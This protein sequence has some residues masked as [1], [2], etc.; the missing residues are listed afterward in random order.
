MRHP[1]NLF[2]ADR[3]AIQNRI[4]IEAGQRTNHAGSSA[5]Q[6]GLALEGYIARS[7]R[8]GQWVANS[9]STVRRKGFNRPLV[10]TAHNASVD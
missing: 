8:T 2:S 4:A 10:D 6:I 9:A 1:W 3:A 7:I 5:A